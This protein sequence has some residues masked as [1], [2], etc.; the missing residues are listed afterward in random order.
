MIVGGEDGYEAGAAE[1]GESAGGGGGGGGGG[2]AWAAC[3][4]L[5]GA[6]SEGDVL[7]YC[8]LV[9]DTSTWQPVAGPRVTRHV[10]LGDAAGLGR[11][12]L[13]GGAVGVPAEMVRAWGL[14][15]F[16]P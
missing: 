14:G 5:V 2:G 1:G 3:P 13:S 11:V 16:P 7:S 6:P 8:P 4:L 9:L 15:D 10:L 12:M